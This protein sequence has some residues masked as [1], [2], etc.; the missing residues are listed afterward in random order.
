MP[1]AIGHYHVLDRLGSAA[2][3]EV[4]RARDARV[5]RTVVLKRLPDTFVAEPSDRERLYRDVEAASRV[6]HPHVAAVYEV[7][8][9]RGGL[10]V[11]QDFV[12]GETLRRVMSG[13][14]LNPGRA[15][16]LAAQ[17][18]DALAEAHAHGL[19][20]RDLQ[21][22][23]VIVTPKGQ[24]KLL[25]L[26]L[27]AFTRSGTLRAS[28]ASAFATADATPPS[29]LPYFSPEQALGEPADHRTDIFSLGVIL[30]EMLTGRPPFVAAG[31]QATLLAILRSVPEAPSRLNP[32]VPTTVD[33]VIVRALAKSLEAR[34]Q[35]AA[36]LAADLRVALQALHARQAAPERAEAKAVRSAARGP[37]AGA[38]LLLALLALALAAIG[39]VYR[40]AIQAALRAVE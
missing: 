40:D 34:Y 17:L 38:W 6:S 3:G 32:A 29:A 27:A 10:F 33:A 19:V 31:A 22:D 15:L 5:G 18:A 36:E 4:W 26:G 16:E 25:D 20:H 39:W 30:Y 28:A 14:P 9:E 2:S 8:E 21:P 7:V 12:P 1:D 13:Q 11:V 35:T 24:V 37:N 23:T